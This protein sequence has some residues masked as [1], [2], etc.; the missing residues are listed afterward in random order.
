VTLAPFA[1]L[2]TLRLTVFGLLVLACASLY[3][4]LTNAGWCMPAL[5]AAVLFATA[6]G[7]W[8]LAREDLTLEGSGA[9][10]RLVLTG[11]SVGL[12]LTWICAIIGALL[13]AASG[14][15]WTHGETQMVL[16]HVIEMTAL[17]WTPLGLVSAFVGTGLA[18]MLNQLDRGAPST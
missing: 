14:A 8:W 5:H 16:R 9:I 11:V 2:N 3:I 7:T 4:A 12:G 17:H 15:S 18:L 6:A 13:D 10:A 1:R